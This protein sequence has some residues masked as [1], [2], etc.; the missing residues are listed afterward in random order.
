[1]P[2]DDF[3]FEQGRRTDVHAVGSLDRF[4][5]NGGIGFIA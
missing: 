3:T 2:R 1:V 5:V 4:A